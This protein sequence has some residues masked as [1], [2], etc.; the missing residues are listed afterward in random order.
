M[1]SS[2][3][4][5]SDEERKKYIRELIKSS[6]YPKLAKYVVYLEDIQ[7]NVIHFDDPSLVL[8]A[9]ELYLD[10]KHLKN[11]KYQFEI[12]VFLLKCGLSL[13]IPKGNVVLHI[14]DKAHDWGVTDDKLYEVFCTFIDWG[15]TDF[16]VPELPDL[17]EYYG[18]Y[19]ETCYDYIYKNQAAI[20]IQ[21]F[22]RGKKK[23]HLSEK[24]HSS[25]DDKIL[26]I[27]E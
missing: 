21:R 20:K 17:S 19:Y 12:V 8:L 6:D 18:N 27:Y 5:M 11:S 10:P 13:F 22:W 7:E 26:F 25:N 9:V 16:L 15:F 4:A 24:N 23:T 14:L 3:M 1:K 2:T